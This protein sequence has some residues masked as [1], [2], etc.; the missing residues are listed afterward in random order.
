VSSN[1]AGQISELINKGRFKEAKKLGEAHQNDE[2]ANQSAHFFF[3]WGLARSLVRKDNSAQ[4]EHASHCADY[5]KQ[6]EGD[7]YRDAALVAAKQ[8][9]LTR[10]A[11]LLF[12]VGDML[13]E[14][15]DLNREAALHMARGRVRYIEESY[16]AALMHHEEAADIWAKAEKASEFVDQQW[17]KNNRFYQLRV[18][19]R[20]GEDTSGL[21]REF[22]QS[23]EPRPDRRVLAFLY[24]YFGKIGVIIGDKFI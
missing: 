18:T 12:M 1:V 20:L 8:G 17:V 19:A 24:H 21:Y 7:F 13:W 14:E 3:Q 4:F 22:H 10:A 23:R 2:N 9:K 11:E 16:E 15:P 5:T 6:M